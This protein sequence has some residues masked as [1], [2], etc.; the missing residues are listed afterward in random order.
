MADLWADVCNDNSP[1][2]WCIL[3][4]EGEEVSGV[5]SGSGLSALIEAL[6]ETKCQWAGFMAYGID[7]VSSKRPKSIQINWVGPRVSPMKRMGALSGK[8]AA[9]QLLQGM[10]LTLDCNDKADL[11]MEDLARQLLACGG[12]H[13]PTYYDFGNEETITL[14]A[15]GY[16]VGN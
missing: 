13:K 4:V 12:A 9:S 15:I 11:T 7:D 2:N 16:S 6:D 5:S 1:T 8:A 14:E 3:E 10:A